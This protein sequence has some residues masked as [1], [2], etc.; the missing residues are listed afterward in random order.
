[1]SRKVWLLVAI[2][3]AALVYKLAFS[4]PEAEVDVEYDA[5]DL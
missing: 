1:M 4:G 3:A 2:V 5:S